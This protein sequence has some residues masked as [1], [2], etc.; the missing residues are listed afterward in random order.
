[1]P[2]RGSHALIFWPIVVVL[3]LAD[4]ITKSVAEAVLWP[5]GVP[6]AVFGDAEWFRWTLVY[7]PGAAFG[8]HLGPYSRWI[9][10]ALTVGALGILY[11]LYRTTEDGNR[12]R[13]MAVGLVTAGAIGNLIDR[14]ISPNGVVDFIDVGVGDMRWPTFNV[15]DMAVSVGAILLATVLWREDEQTARV[16]EERE[17]AARTVSGSSRVRT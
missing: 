8:L 6:R 5:R 16:T 12:W 17:T 11:H 14:I 4:R 13:V 9:F 1:M 3:V 10:L 2:R 15:A 7:N